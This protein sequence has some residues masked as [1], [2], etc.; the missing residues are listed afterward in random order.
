M[1]A[2]TK[3]IFHYYENCIFIPC[4]LFDENQNGK[5][6]KFASKQSSK[7]KNDHRQDQLAS[8]EYVSGCT[9]NYSDAHAFT[10]V[11]HS[12]WQMRKKKQNSNKMTYRN[13]EEA[14][15]NECDHLDG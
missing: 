15:Q 5:T 6:V 2:T 11:L 8:T 9:I 1:N 4:F 10:L 7:W 12:I 13:V 14:T 3:A